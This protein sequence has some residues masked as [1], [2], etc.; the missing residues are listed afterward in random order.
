MS[1]IRKVSVWVFLVLSLVLALVLLAVEIGV[2]TRFVNLNNVNVTLYTIVV[3]PLWALNAYPAGR[4]LRLLG[5][6]IS[7][8]S[9]AVTE[10]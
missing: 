5:L 9:K 3:L 7:K 8:T 4:L 10:S 2:F 1:S 6:R